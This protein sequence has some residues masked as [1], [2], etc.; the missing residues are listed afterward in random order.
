MELKNV[1]DI[2][3]KDHNGYITEQEL[4]QS[5]AAMGHKLSPQEVEELMKEAD[6]N[7]D[8]LIDFQEF[9]AAMKKK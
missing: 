4:S 6:Q 1:F 9:K 5:M 8:R 7:G 3:D 2:M